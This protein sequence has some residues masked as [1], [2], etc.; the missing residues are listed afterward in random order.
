MH[1]TRHRVFLA[2]LIVAAKYLNDS[3]PKNKHWT[4]YAALFSLA[5]VSLME[6]QLLY[7]L[8][9]DLRMTEDEL[10]IHFQPFLNY[11]PHPHAAPVVLQH[12]ASRVPSLESC[13]SSPPTSP[14]PVTPQR[15]SRSAMQSHNEKKAQT[16][17]PSPAPSPIRRTSSHHSQSSPY[18]RTSRPRR[19]TP[20]SSDD[21]M[22]SQPA[23]VQEPAPARRLGRN[24]IASL[25]AAAQQAARRGSQEALTRQASAVPLQLNLPFTAN[26][27]HHAR[28][29]ASNGNPGTLR[30][31]TSSSNL[32]ASVKGYFNRMQT[33]DM[34]DEQHTMV[35]D[36]ITVVT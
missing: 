6:K 5:E 11:G 20:S 3:S 29:E 19:G 33:R 14:Y 30:S 12:I 32:I 7:L 18:A 23:E 13:S 16:A 28:R 24:S 31:K 27:L 4:R 36:G 35:V 22:D 21:E 34:G 26:E 8:D 10:I 9:Y 17:F 1:C 25:Q 2:T 15:P